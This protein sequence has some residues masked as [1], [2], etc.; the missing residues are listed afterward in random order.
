MDAP[1]TRSQEAPVDL[2][3]I[4]LDATGRR[5][6]TGTEHAAYHVDVDAVLRDPSVRRGYD[7]GSVLVL[8]LV[9]G[10]LA[11]VVG[12]TSTIGRDDDDGGATAAARSA[13]ARSS[14]APTMPGSTGAAR[15]ADPV[16]G[17]V[18]PLP[19]LTVSSVAAVASPTG[20]MLVRAVISNDGARAL[21]AGSRGE[22]LVLLDGTVTTTHRIPAIEPG[23]RARVELDVAW[24]VEGRHAV[25]AVADPSAAVRE[26]D[27]RDN[28]TSRVV[29]LDC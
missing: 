2:A 6:S 23:S 14:G 29:Q 3:G 5:R 24:C 22:V 8:A 11:A 9:V 13:A 17:P 12:W 7:P 27:E 1:R 10:V 21:L 19:D 25:T 26:A 18:L 28:A 16:A 15:G 20:R 4:V